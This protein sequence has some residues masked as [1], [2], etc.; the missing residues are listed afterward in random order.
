MATGLRCYQCER[1][2][3]RQ[4]RHNNYQVYA[5]TGANLIKIGSTT[6]DIA[7]RF[8]SLLTGSP[9]PLRL[10]G[11]VHV[12][13]NSEQRIHVLLDAHRVRG[14]WFR[15]DGDVL[16][17]TEWIVEKNAEA[18]ETWINASLSAMSRNFY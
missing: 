15:P 5:V 7:N 8:S 16:K 2:K 4:D 6:G 3:R 13:H 10:L 18:L 1:R 9:I 17:V 11:S 14:E 12:L